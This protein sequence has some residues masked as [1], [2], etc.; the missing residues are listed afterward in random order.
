MPGP[1]HIIDVLRT[2]QLTDF[3]RPNMFEVD[4]LPP[5]GAVD[6]SNLFLTQNLVKGITLPST[7][8]QDMEIR[9]MGRKLSI[10]VA[11]QFDRVSV[12]LRDDEGGKVRNFFNQWQRN[13]YGD[14]ESGVFNPNL[15]HLISGEVHI[16]QL[17]SLHERTNKIVVKHAHPSLLG[18]MELNHDTE[19]STSDFSVTILFAYALY[20]NQAKTGFADIS[21]T[22][23]I[24]RT[25]G[26]L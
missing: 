1:R 8:V 21:V 11:T 5:L 10:P 6:V 14:I 22:P 7:S 20:S 24:D 25:A 23:Q 2:S 15:K 26:E 19:D 16:Y 17:N 3:H 9:R 4:F 12:T 18:E 13:H